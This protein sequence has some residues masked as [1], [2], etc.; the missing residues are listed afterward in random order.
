MK[1]SKQED[2]MKILAT[3]R[4]SYEDGNILSHK[5]S[6][7]KVLRGG[8]L[9]A[10]YKQYTL[11]DGKRYG[12]GTKVLVYAHILVYMMHHG[13]YPVGLEIDH[14]DRDVSNNRIENLRAVP[15]YINHLNRSERDST[16]KK[17]RSIRHK[18]IKA[19]RSLM[20]DGLSQYAIA[21]K[22]NLGISATRYIIK[23]I[24]AG[25]SLKYEL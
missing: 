2:L 13:E 20:K 24:E 18:E 11:F 4:Y 22:L 6:G 17:Q 19:I 12:R 15:T 25:E 1:K 9:P 23:K 14:I 10:G 7:V 16:Y 8:M 21:R 5:P 3:G